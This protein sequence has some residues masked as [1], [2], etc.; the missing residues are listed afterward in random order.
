MKEIIKSIILVGEHAGMYIGIISYACL[1]FT[2]LFYLPI[3]IIFIY[4]HYLFNNLPRYIY[5]FELI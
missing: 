2:K 5:L 4:Y 3:I 1:I